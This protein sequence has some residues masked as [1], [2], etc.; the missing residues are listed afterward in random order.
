MGDY[1]RFS[2]TK[3]TV[4]GNDGEPYILNSDGIFTLTSAA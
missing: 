3:I 1:V 4:L 2:N